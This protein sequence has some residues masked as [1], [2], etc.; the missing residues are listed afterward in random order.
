MKKSK[1]VVGFYKALLSSLNIEPTDDG[2]LSYMVHGDDGASSL[3]ITLGEKEYRLV[4]PDDEN[5]MRGIGEVTNTI[6]FHPI[7]EVLLH[8]E[9]AVIKFL[10]RYIIHR[11]KSVLVTHINVLAEIATT[12]DMH[13][14]LTAKQSEFLTQLPG[15]KEPFM[16]S[17]DSLVR[18]MA[19]GTVSAVNIYLKRDDAVDGVN[20]SRVAR[21]NFPVLRDLDEDGNQ[22]GGVDFKSAK[23]KKLFGVLFNYIIPDAAVMD[24][25]TG[26]TDAKVAPYFIALLKAY[27]NIAKRLN[28]VTE[29]FSDRFPHTPELIIDLSWMAQLGEIDS[30]RDV[31]P[32]LAGNE[33]SVEKT[34]TTTT[35][36]VSTSPAR[37]VQVA[38]PSTA[39]VNVEQQ[40]VQQQTVQQQPTAQ[41]VAQ[42]QSNV[43]SSDDGDTVDWSSYSR[44]MV[45]QQQLQPQ[46]NMGG[47]NPYQNIPQQPAQPSYMPAN[48]HPSQMGMAY[49]AYA[50]NMA[51]QP[52]YPHQQPQNVGY[53]PFQQQNQPMVQQN[54]M[55]NIQNKW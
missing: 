50:G 53:N 34:P 52:M 27:A 46:V 39:S 54:Q 47:Y 10:K 22:V 5:M 29:L 20:Y 21:V 17:V 51:P 7:S 48:V 42:Q 33:G 6:G 2:Y 55:V 9:S 37:R 19:H 40:P 44:T 49:N 3:P 18:K 36:S 4:L 23:A 24:A 16:K 26:A 31:I 11:V 13:K 28:E 12:V 43:E 15:V 32:P 35:S 41:P 8:G 38:P 25:Y 1:L 30:W 14:T 45:P